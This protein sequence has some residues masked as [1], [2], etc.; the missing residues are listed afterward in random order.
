MSRSVSDVHYRR[1]PAGYQIWYV[2][3]VSY[4]NANDPQPLPYPALL[5]ARMA[6]YSQHNNNLII[7][8]LAWTKD[9][10]SQSVWKNLQTVTF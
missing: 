2:F 3:R 4:K 8:R 10:N 9:V 7:K 6:G 5:M 1:P